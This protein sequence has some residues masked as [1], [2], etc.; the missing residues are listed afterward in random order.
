MSRDHYRFTILGCGSS[1]GVPRIG[2]DWGK[3]DPA[4]PKNRRRRCSALVERR[5]ERGAT[6]VLID[7]GPD[8]R[9]QLLSVGLSHLDGVLYTHD[10]A[11]HTHG[12]D[13]LRVLAYRMKSRIDIWCDAQTKHSLLT[14]FGYCFE[15]PKGSTYPSIFK[16]HDIAIGS[17]VTVEGRGGAITA[18]PMAQSHGKIDSVGFRF[19]GLAYSSDCSD[20]GDATVAA[21]Q[22][23]DVWIVDGLRHEKHP[24]HF[25]VC[26]A[27]EWIER[28]RP[29]RAILTHMHVDLDYDTLR[30]EL[31][32]GVEPAYDGMTIDFDG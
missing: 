23:L 9:E 2:G 10:H 21:L 32:A 18:L 16:A 5:S 1:G 8:V 7:T 27:L 6:T 4:N 3:C 25:T 22:G 11:D 15:Q 29:R 31:P 12:I 26:Q 24:A 13:D 30:R 14:R 20:F 28:V 17:P 19:G